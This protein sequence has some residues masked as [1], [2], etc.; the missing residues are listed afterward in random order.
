MMTNKQRFHLDL[1]DC[2]TMNEV[3]KVCNNFYNLDEKLSTVK[4]QIILSGIKQALNLI[5]PTE[6]KA[7]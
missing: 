3:F 1:S 4:K 5:N 6:K 2:N 7:L